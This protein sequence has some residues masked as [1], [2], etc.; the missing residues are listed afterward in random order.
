MGILIGIIDHSAVI[1]IL[2]G[3][4]FISLGDLPNMIG[5]AVMVV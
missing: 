2:S 5:A 3:V 4:K 1:F